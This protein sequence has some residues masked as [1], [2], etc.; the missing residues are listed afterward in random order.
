M[1]KRT[2]HATIDP[3]KVAALCERNSWSIADLVR[4]LEEIG[5]RRF[6]LDRHG[7]GGVSAG[8]DT[9]GGLCKVLGCKPN[10]VVSLVGS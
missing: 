3:K 2:Q 10:D 7:P 4:R 6:R 5:V 9:V 8:L 1:K